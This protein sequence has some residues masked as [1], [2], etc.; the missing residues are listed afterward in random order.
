[1][2]PLQAGMLFHNLADPGSGVDIEHVTVKFNENLDVERIKQSWAHAISNRDALRSSFDWSDANGPYQLVHQD[3]DFPLIELDWSNETSENVARQKNKCM[4]DDRAQGF[5]LNTPP[6]RLTIAK[7]QNNHYWML[8]SFH[9]IIL[10]GR[11]FELVLKDVLSFYDEGLFNKLPPELSF[12]AYAK[13]L[14][15]KEQN[16]GFWVDHYRDVDASRT[17]GLANQ[18]AAIKTT[19]EK[20][21]YAYKKVALPAKAQIDLRLLADN[22][23]ISINT[24]IQT[25]WALLLHHY[26]NQD[27]VA[28]ASTRA[29][30]HQFP[31]AEK[32]A[33][34]LINTLPFRVEVTNR[35]TLLELLQSVKEE[36]L[37]LRQAENTSLSI[38]QENVPSL[39]SIDTLVMFDNQNL[40]SRMRG[41]PHSQPS[42][43][44]FAYD[45]QTNY[46]ITLIAYD[47]PELSVR[48]E[49]WTDVL[50]EKN[51]GRILDQLTNLLV[52][53]VANINEPAINVPYLSASELTQ[54]ENWNNTNRAY[55]PN[56]TLMELFEAQVARTPDVPALIFK[57]QH[58]TYRELNAKSN[59]LAGYIRDQGVQADELVG[60]F[61]ERSLEMLICIYSILKA[62][63]AYVP[64]DPEYPADRL[65]FMIEDS[66]ARLVIVDENLVEKLPQNDVTLLTVQNHSLWDQYPDSNLAPQAKPNN[67]AYMIYTS[68]S[69]GKP[70]GVMN[71]HRGIVNRLL[72]MQETFNIDST[73]VVFQKTPTS[74]DVSVWELFWPLQVGARLVIAEPQGHRDTAYLTSTIIENEVTTMHFVPSM[75]QLFVEDPN[76]ARCKCLKKII[77]SGEALPLKLQK[78]LFGELEVELH[79]LYGPTEAAVDVTWWH[80]KADSELNFIPIGKAI[81]NTQIHIL[82]K[83]M[84]RV[85]VG[86]SGELHIGGVQVARG[87]RNRDELTAEMFVEDP[88]DATYKLYKTGDL[89]RFL[90][91]GNIEYLGRIDF[92]VKIRGQRI[93]LGE[94]ESVISSFQK[95][96]EVV[97]TADLDPAG[98]QVLV[99][100]FVGTSSIVEELKLHCSNFLASHMIPTVWMA[101][102]SFPLNT[103]GKVDRKCLPPP[104]FD[105]TA[106]A[107]CSPLNASGT[108]LKVMSA[109][110]DVLGKKNLRLDRTFFDVGGNSLSLMRLANRLAVEFDREITIQ[111]LLRESTIAKQTQ[112]FDDPADKT[113]KTVEKAKNMSRRRRVARARR[114]SS[115]K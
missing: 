53:F 66:E 36:Q 72:W 35:V 6:I 4:K 114:D 39:A 20:V 60:V 112:F 65:A 13:S 51:S 67:L 102:D 109:W 84:N 80:C 115:N 25:A 21:P 55:N 91:D 113:D 11:S 76:I 85:P 41:K 56:S 44:T 54:L 98:D 106:T 38:V 103:S 58:I 73:D 61:L 1:M 40:D 79:N 96:N 7:I 81:A 24:V 110:E 88:F 33:G 92:Q 86:T 104:V 47:H 9:H 42:T 50:D 26:T 43:R 23:A 97:V 8:W 64:L 78:R 45:G 22:H 32:V 71:E 37:T 90:A 70:K 107:T 30:R 94:V 95:V 16:Q 68:G 27:I 19:D 14:N 83:N 15:N 99:G 17:F 34:L 57:N 62:G 77:C 2:T 52:N 63:A 101:M 48:L 100:Y 87:Y 93:E 111:T 5:D 3:F 75:L 105:E 31:N 12:A 69:T 10:D 28:F 49:Y 29:I 18:I 82:D 74:F 46:P 108:T 59:Q 89:A